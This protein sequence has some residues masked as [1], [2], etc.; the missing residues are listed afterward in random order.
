MFCYTTHQ[1]LPSQTSLHGLARDAMKFAKSLDKTPPNT[2]GY[3]SDANAKL[4]RLDRMEKLD[5]LRRQPKIQT[6]CIL[7]SPCRYSVMTNHYP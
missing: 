5:V 6:S 7:Q 1:I 4:D 2:I 3:R